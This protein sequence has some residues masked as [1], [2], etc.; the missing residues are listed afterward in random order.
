MKPKT[1]NPAVQIVLTAEQ[2]RQLAEQIGGHAT[3]VRLAPMELERRLAPGG[4][5][6]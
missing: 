6:N 4:D 1:Q 3:V 2:Q 5:L